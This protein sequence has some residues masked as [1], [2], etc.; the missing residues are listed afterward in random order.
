MGIHVHRNVLIIALRKRLNIST[1]N[2]FLSREVFVCVDIDRHRYPVVAPLAQSNCSIDKQK[3]RP[4]VPIHATLAR[5]AIEK[6]TTKLTAIVPEKRASARSVSMENIYM[7]ALRANATATNMG[8]VE[9]GGAVMSAQQKEVQNTS[10]WLAWHD[11][12]N[13]TC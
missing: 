11:R 4:T 13:S 2:V 10:V 3:S 6:I 12:K 1:W 7:K 9:T 5:N 8:C